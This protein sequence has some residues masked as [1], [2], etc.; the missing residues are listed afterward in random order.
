M[1]ATSA[2][3]AAR[4]AAGGSDPRG[5]ETNQAVIRNTHT[6]VS[7]KK[8]RSPQTRSFRQ[9]AHASVG[10]YGGSPGA[11]SRHQTE[12]PQF[13]PTSVCLGKTLWHRNPRP[14]PHL[15][16]FDGR[17]FS[18]TSTKTPRCRNPSGRSGCRG[19]HIPSMWQE[20]D[21]LLPEALE[22]VTPD[23]VH[24]GCKEAILARRKALQIRTLVARREN[25]RKLAR[26]EQESRA[27]T[28]HLYLNSPPD[29]SQL[30]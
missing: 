27:G 2:A 24:S 16:S 22:H 5:A 21:R 11:E 9:R 1:C 10:T 17:S 25:Y 30:C 15:R 13:D 20:G 28:P 3:G 4:D 14:R 7:V 12:H 18:S 19:L 8:R 26:R 29:L 23:D 6:P